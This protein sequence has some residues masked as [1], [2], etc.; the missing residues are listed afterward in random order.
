MLKDIEF[1]SA[2]KKMKC[3]PPKDNCHVYDCLFSLSLSAFLSLLHWLT[4]I[5]HDFLNDTYLSSLL[6]LKSKLSRSCLLMLLYA[7]FF[8]TDHN[9]DLDDLLCVGALVVVM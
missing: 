2:E 8:Y 5:F 7:T 6:Y 3:D 1:T 9:E 4:T